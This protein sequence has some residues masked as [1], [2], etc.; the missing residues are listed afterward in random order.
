MAKDVSSSGEKTPRQPADAQR[1]AGA[2]GSHPR[3]STPKD[4][5]AK[6][7]QAKGAGHVA[8]KVAGKATGAKKDQPQ[9][10]VSAAASGATRGAVEGGL[11][12][13]PQG[14]AVGA[15][16][17]A[18]VD[19]AKAAGDRKK[20][21]DTDEPRLG[22]GGTSEIGDEAKKQEDDQAKGADDDTKGL[23]TGQ[24]AA[25]G[26][27]A[28]PA[29]AVAAQLAVIAMFVKL[30]KLSLA[31]AQLMMQ[32]FF[33]WL[34]NTL[35]SIG[36][37]ILAPV[38]AVGSAVASALGSAASVPATIVTTLVGFGTVVAGGVGM[39][40]EAATTDIAQRDG[41]LLET[42]APMDRAGAQQAVNLEETGEATV[43]AEKAYA[44]LAGMG[45]PDEN[46]S[47]IL[48]NWHE[49][50]SIDP[51]G[52]ETVLDEGFHIGPEKQAAWDV[53]WDIAAFNPSYAAT[54]PNIDKMGIGLG[55]WTNGRNTLLMNFSE[56]LGD[57]W[58]EIETQ[59]AFMVRADD[60]SRVSYM[61]GL[62]DESL[63][64]PDAATQSFMT[65]WEGIND[66]TD[67]GRIQAA[68]RYMSLMSGWE[69]DEALANSILEAADAAGD[70]ASSSARRVATSNAADCEDVTVLASGLMVG[71]VGSGDWTHPLPGGNFS[72]G[73]GPRPCP[74]GATCNE[75]TTQHG[76]VDFSS[77][78]G[79]EVV[80]VTDMEITAVGT[81][82]YQGHHIVARQENPDE[83]DGYVF[84]FH[85]C[86]A[87]SAQVAVGNTVAVGEPICTEGSTGNSTG[88][89]LHFQIGTP[90]Q[91]DSKP[92]Q[93]HEYAIDPE[94]I[95]IEAGVDF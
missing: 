84:Q 25:V 91:D 76:G 35:I 93:T 62:V 1:A 83:G 72:S 8:G 4:R 32:T 70:S 29:V 42:C 56:E 58:Y 3:A 36:K 54:H 67:S 61:Q 68:E 28:I 88:P 75:F 18:A 23:S 33:A 39:M 45:M 22:A 46:I 6:T 40:Q 47:G 86:E 27:A 48:G 31:A 38:L 41:G 20:A 66:G 2:K 30:L 52:V 19:S 16:T 95:L 60:P 79:N 81:N 53:N 17:G 49:E 92:D 74:A 7:A 87:N 64:S 43:Q 14:V 69:A 63:G 77:G 21:G 89:H 80:A 24:K 55:Q 50:S 59:L 82:E 34:V 51:T 37:A 71:D 90:D 94:P 57:P 65:E 78:G 15:A 73:F 5:L 11:K 44:F 12:A 85:H 10:K 9:G 26:A 13:G